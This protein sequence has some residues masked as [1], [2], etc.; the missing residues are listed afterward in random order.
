ML[1]LSIFHLCTIGEHEVQSE[2]AIN[3]SFTL[4]G[5]WINKA[6]STS[7]TEIPIHHSL[8]MD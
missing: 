5:L 3:L 8:L 4:R 2:V 1:I 6:T 7:D